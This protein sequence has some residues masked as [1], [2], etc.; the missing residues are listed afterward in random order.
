MHPPCSCQAPRKHAQKNS[1]CRVVRTLFIINRSVILPRAQRQAIHHSSI[2][3]QEGKWHVAQQHCRWWPVQSGPHT[4]VYMAAYTSTDSHA[5][6]MPRE[7]CGSKGADARSVPGCGMALAFLDA[8]GEALCDALGHLPQLPQPAIGLQ[9]RQRAGQR[10]HRV[11][12]LPVVLGRQ[13]HLHFHMAQSW[14]VPFPVSTTLPAVTENIP[15]KDV[16]RSRMRP[17]QAAHPCIEDAKPVRLCTSIAKRSATSPFATFLSSAGRCFG[18]RAGP[19]R[20]IGC[21]WRGA[22]HLE[23]YFE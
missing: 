4:H 13:R 5:K 11:L 19:G 16:H 10:S 6:D 22:A 23:R 12:L 20:S 1:T 18:S 17:M 14:T 15:A 2:H 3:R 9:P 8:L 7:C 21:S